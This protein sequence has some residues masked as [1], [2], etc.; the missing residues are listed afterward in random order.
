MVYNL[1][2]YSS[3]DAQKVFGIIV[4]TI[5]LLVFIVG[6]IFYAIGSA[7]L[8][9]SILSKKKISFD[10]KDAPLDGATHVGE[11]VFQ[12]KEVSLYSKQD[13]FFL[14]SRKW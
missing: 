2:G 3:M 5:I 11:T 12:G 7:Q 4:L 13:K 8:I 6:T 9:M 14:W 1:S 10:E